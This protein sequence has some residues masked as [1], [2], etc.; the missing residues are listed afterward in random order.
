MAGSHADCS[1]LQEHQRAEAAARDHVIAELHRRAARQAA[2]WATAQ[3]LAITWLQ[4]TVNAEDADYVQHHMDIVKMVLSGAGMQATG[5]AAVTSDAVAHKPMAVD[6][7][8]AAAQKSMQQGLVDTAAAAVKS[9]AAGQ[10]TAV[11]HAA[12]MN[13]SAADA[14]AAQAA[15][16]SAAAV[17]SLQATAVDTTAPAVAVALAIDEAA[18]A[19]ADAKAKATATAEAVLRAAVAQEQQKVLRRASEQLFSPL[20]QGLVDYPSDEDS[21]MSRGMSDTDGDTTAALL[22]RGTAA[23]SN[24]APRAKAVAGLASLLPMY[25][26]D[27]SG[28]GG[29]K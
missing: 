10:A 29:H 21:H 20:T 27:L 3:Q 18:R 8:M 5:V 14:S 17:A 2:T 11:A 6:M 25:S 24:L 1:H 19:L 7:P 16:A 28:T 9:A 13:A 12:G 23:K 22:S 15:A 26:A 4:V